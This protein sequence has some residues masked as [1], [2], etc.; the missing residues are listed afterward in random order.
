MDELISD[1]IYTPL[2]CI[3]GSY[4]GGV[5]V[6]TPLPI[7]LTVVKK[8][9]LNTNV[10]SIMVPFP[11]GELSELFPGKIGC[12]S[13]NSLGMHIFPKDVGPEIIFLGPLKN[14][15]LRNSL[16]LFI[17]GGYRI[18]CLFA[19]G[20]YDKNYLVNAILRT[21]IASVVFRFNN[22]ISNK[23]KSNLLFFHFERLVVFLSGVKLNSSLRSLD[24]MLLIDREF[25]VNKNKI[26]V[27]GAGLGPGGA[28]R[29]M[30]LSMVGLKDRGYDVTF[31]HLH[32]L[33]S[34]NNFYI[35]KLKDAGIEI[36]KIKNYFLETKNIEVFKYLS[37]LKNHD[38][39]II[40]LL[41]YLREISKSKP[42]VVHAWQ[43]QVGVYAGLAALIVGVPKIIISWRSLAPDNFNFN[44]TY[45]RDVY[46][47][48]AGHANVLFLNNS[49][50]GA[51]D[52][53]RWLGVQKINV[54]VIHNGF[55]LSALPDKGQK[56]IIK[57]Y[58]RK[59]ISLDDKVL[60]VGAVMR[61]SEEKQPHLFIKIA[62]EI[63]KKVPNM[64]FFIVGDGP[65]MK[66][67]VAFANRLIPGK[68]QF[69]GHQK[70]VFDYILA[71]DL[72]ILTSRAEGLPNVLME[73]QALGIPVMSTRSGGAVEAIDE[74]F[75]GFFFDS[76]NLQDAAT[77]AAHILCN[78]SWRSAATLLGPEFI[79]NKFNLREMV[80]KTI[81]AYRL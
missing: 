42:E 30:A 9:L 50:A 80:D 46:K 62:C 53:S 37:S 24:R 67:V 10:I 16:K 5:T 45:M 57:K 15:G 35:Q 78:E 79:I 29:Q 55:D 19:Q 68:V 6:I 1:E 3:I 33:V 7:S 11:C 14:L 34:P 27:I 18:T 65:L 39:L 22:L 47:F 21:C 23:S 38:D 28:E 72:L 52:Y 74:G 20:P 66:E 70:N 61:F 77:K 13:S 4:R 25:R 81:A 48:L 59:I 69:L 31:L 41:P 17:R 60:V 32:S 8:I 64:H 36:K 54:Q 49:H 2:E 44:R 75:T 76:N 71:M 56:V 43:D 63:L 58:I 73:A 51:K 12:F 40:E 26:L